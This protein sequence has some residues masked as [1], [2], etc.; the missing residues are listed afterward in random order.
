[1]CTFLI[2]PTPTRAYQRLPSGKS[3]MKSFDEL[4]E[5]QDN[6]EC[7]IYISLPDEYHQ[8]RVCLYDP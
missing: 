6:L 1:M 2:I 8:R 4:M 7:D 5:L 3:V